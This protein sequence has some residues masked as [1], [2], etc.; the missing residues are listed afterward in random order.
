MESTKEILREYSTDSFKMNVAISGCL[1]FGSLLKVRDGTDKWR[2]TI[3]IN[4]KCFWTVPG[5]HIVKYFGIFCYYHGYL[6]FE[7]I[8]V[9]REFS[10]QQ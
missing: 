5:T 7:R 9:Q 8:R 1:L 10:S 2:L 3:L 4:I 6:K